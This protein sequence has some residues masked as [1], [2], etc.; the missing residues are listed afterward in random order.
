VHL[1][2]PLLNAPDLKDGYLPPDIGMAVYLVLPSVM[3]KH[4]HDQE[5]S[6]RE[7][8][9]LALPKRRSVVDSNP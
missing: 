7:L 9:I 4:R 8:E 6:G 1:P 2:E 3:A 5:L